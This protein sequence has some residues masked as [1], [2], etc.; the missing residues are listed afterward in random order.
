MMRLPFIILVFMLAGCGIQSTATDT[1]NQREKVRVHAENWPRDPQIVPLYDAV[2][3]SLAVGASTGG[4]S[5]FNP[6]DEFWGLPPVDTGTHTLVAAYCGACHSLKIVMQ[7]RASADRWD[8]LITWM[9]D[10]QGM[11]PLDADERNQIVRYL[12]TYFTDT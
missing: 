6:A 1:A 5:L 7:Q 10:K 8:D 2:D 4:A 11:P 12:G 3:P 9:V